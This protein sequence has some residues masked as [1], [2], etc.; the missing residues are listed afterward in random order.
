M[1]TYFIILLIS[2]ITIYSCSV[3]RNSASPVLTNQLSK[4]SRGNDMLLGKCTRA[5]LLQSPFID[6]YKPNYDSY[7]VDSFTCNF[8]RPLLAGKSVTIFLGT[9]C[10]DS[11]REVP[12]VLKML[13]CCGF[14]SN[15]ITLIMV[16][17]R[18]SLYK[19]S[20]QHEETGKN[21]VRV[22]TI[23][24]EQKGVEIGRII[25]FPKTSLEKDLLSI[26]RK[27][28]YQPNYHHLKADAR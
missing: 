17:N 19:K 14:S 20:P 22:P 5:A 1:K 21:I 6:W 25:E 12:R 7:H 26:L 13:D 8:I 16:S 4:D 9:W 15:N 18:D 23:I 3:N 10:G 2:S 28:K 24:I 11:K 27:E